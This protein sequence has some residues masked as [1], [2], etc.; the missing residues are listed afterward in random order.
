MTG[1]TTTTNRTVADAAIES[2]WSASTA[3]RADEAVLQAHPLVEIGSGPRF[4]DD[5]VWDLN[6][7][8]RPANRSPTWGRLLFRRLPGRWNLRAR[9]IA[10]AMLNP[11]HPALRSAGLF[12]PSGHADPHTVRHCVRGLQTLAV[13]AFERDMPTDLSE[14]N[15]AQLEEFV[16]TIAADRQPGAVRPYVFSIRQLHLFAPLLTGGGLRLDPWA[17]RS[18]AE[19]AGLTRGRGYAEVLTE[20]IAPDTW[21]PLVRA[22][23]TYVDVFA[24]DILA[25]RTRR[26]ELAAARGPLGQSRG[27]ELF[28]EWI[29]RPDASVPLH[30][31][32][33]SP[34]AQRGEVNWRLLSLQ[35]TQGRSDSLLSGV[36]GRRATRRHRVLAL[37]EA[38]RGVVGGLGTP[39]ALRDRA[40]GTQGPWHADFDA[41]SLNVELVMLRN[42]CY[43]FCAAL[44]MM[45]DSELQA[46]ERDALTTYYGAPALRSV[47]RKLDSARPV[48]HWWVIDP[49]AKAVAVAAELSW[50]DSHIFASQYPSRTSPPRHHVNGRAGIYAGTAIDTFVAH[51]NAT[52]HLTGLQ[53]VPEGRVR[54]HMFRRT[55]AIVA[56]RQPDGEI[57]LGLTLKHAA[58][59]A[60]ANR[61]TGGYA[62]MDARWAKEFDVE[63]EEQTAVQLVGIWT[64][65]T[66]GR[67]VA[68]G[69][70]G[71]LFHQ[72]LDD[73]RRQLD[74]TDGELRAQLGDRRLLQRLL[75]DAL[76][77]LRLGHLNHCLGDLAQAEC[78]RDAPADLPRQDVLPDRC[79]PGRCRNSV[80]TTAE[81][82]P[83][84]IAEEAD[85]TRMLRTPRLAPEHRQQL[86]GELS[87]VRTVTRT[88]TAPRQRQ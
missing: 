67:T 38:G 24:D 25:A 19:V 41:P 82:L 64:R 31:T 3:F 63:M 69:P 30:A 40:D 79:K 4:G 44:T 70:G 13:W 75:R 73:V 27:P 7:L 58:R 47:K 53:E 56:G 33:R 66:A 16:R 1:G 17:G 18:T 74:A 78:L 43:V 52:A 86:Q 76:S 77:G 39:I 50:H 11:T 5:E 72:A 2:S 55:M 71:D 14:W 80:V 87:E 81:H 9:E 6:A 8:G 88:G 20:A 21:W 28:E 29:A 49:V 32:T 84:W 60:L 65:R 51:V 36:K 10:M 59:R 23:W 68:V 37:V 62:A 57:A 83:H 61:T 54:P 46:L 34:R 45:R 22:A 85:L 35:I 12:L 15:P 48:Q 42:A 26:D